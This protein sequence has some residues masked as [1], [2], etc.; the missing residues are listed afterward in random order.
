M[1]FQLEVTFLVHVLAL[2]VV[3]CYTHLSVFGRYHPDVLYRLE[4]PTT[5]HCLV[6]F[7]KNYWHLVKEEKPDVAPEI[8]PITSPRG[9]EGGD[10]YQEQQGQQQ[11]FEEAR[12]RE[13]E[14]SAAVTASSGR[15]TPVM[16]SRPH[17]CAR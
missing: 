16:F 2:S 6:H 10:Y 5:Y 3:L 14:A 12:I 13:E 1:G 17:V 11:M 8:S 15:L 7:R 4:N 9:E